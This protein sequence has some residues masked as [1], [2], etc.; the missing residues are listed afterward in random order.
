MANNLPVP[1][2]ILDQH[3]VL[4]G[5][6]RAG[7]SSTMRVL[8]EQLLE[9]GQPVCIIDPKGDWWGLKLSASGKSAGYPIVIFG[10]KHADVQINARAGAQIA[11]LIATGNRPCLID[12]KG[13]TVTDRT[14]FW[15][16]FASTL[17][18]KTEGKRWLA[19][20]EVH[21][22]APKGKVLDPSAGK[23]LHWANRLGSEGLGLGLHLIFASQRPQKVHNDLLTSAETLIAKRVIHKADRDAVGDWIDGCGDPAMGKDVMAGLAALDRSEG[24]VWSPEIGFGPKLIKFP[25][26]TTYDSF[27]AQDAGAA[28]K[29]K[30]WASVDL[31][32]VN[33][34]LAAIIEQEKH[35][36]PAWLRKL[37]S[38]QGIVVRD[39]QA[40][41][42]KANDGKIDQAVAQF[43]AAFDAAEA[44]V[45]AAMV[46]IGEILNKA[47]AELH[48]MLKAAHADMA[49]AYK[50]AAL[51]AAKKPVPV[52]TEG[53]RKGGRNVTPSKIALV[54][55][56][57]APAPI[58]SAAPPADGAAITPMVR[59]IIDEIHRANPMALSFEA[60]ALRA[61][62]SIRSSAYEKYRKQVNACGEVEP[63]ADGKLQSAAGFAWQP[64]PGVNPVDA[65]MSRLQPS[66][67]AMLRV[68]AAAT[69][70]ITK[71]EVAA[72]AGISPTS[73]G[74]PAGLNELKALSLIVEENKAYSLNPEL[75]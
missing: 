10:G 2:K 17:F 67:G 44:S 59:K 72:G 53:P 56:P 14:Q 70:P 66:Y 42:A 16:D 25:M 75:I 8:V 73:S 68:I 30:G 35:N 20:D 24:W 32:E 64:T 22:F 28:A 39:L 46:R 48:P 19:I 65:F 60:A 9:D 71:D 34:R 38:Q 49:K 55:R 36:D 50:E 11:E 54:Q 43:Q 47:M 13:W 12:L 31:K 40:Q 51:V 58:F 18:S 3:V 33:T 69:A 1:K 7:K 63:R 5:K 52:L 41:L 15:I 23:A 26:F 37:V 57:A 74:L 61:G 6:T 27:K 62:V 29:L 45:R 4:L 21:N